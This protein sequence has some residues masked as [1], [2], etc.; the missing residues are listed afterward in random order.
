MNFPCTGCSACCRDLPSHWAFNRGDG[1]CRHLDTTTQRCA[2]Y[3]ERPLICRIGDLYQQRLA[4]RLTPRVYYLVQAAGC[5]SR[6][7]RNQEVPAAV[8]QCLAEAQDS[9]SP[10]P[11]PLSDEEMNAGLATILADTAPLIARL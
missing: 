10:A 3:A 7:P 9:A 4:K 8:L 11:A 1:I 5:V 2:V 6:D